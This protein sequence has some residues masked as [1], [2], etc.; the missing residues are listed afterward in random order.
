MKLP[1]QHLFSMFHAP[2]VSIG[3]ESDELEPF[4]PSQIEYIQ[5]VKPR[6][7]V[8]LSCLA[9]ILDILKRAFIASLRTLANDLC[10]IMGYYYL[11]Y[12]KK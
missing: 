7:V 11:T 8:L 4:E 5:N 6:M 10:N 2:L 3:I 1:K 12:L 9:S